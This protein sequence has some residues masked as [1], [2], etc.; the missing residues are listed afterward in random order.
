MSFVG[1]CCSCQD[2]SGDLHHQRGE[3]ESEFDD[4]ILKVFRPLVQLSEADSIFDVKRKIAEQ[5]K[6]YAD[7][8]RQELRLEPKGKF[9]K[10][11]ERLEK[12][13][14][15]NGAI[16]Y[17]K[18]RGLQ[19]GWTTVF[20][21]EYAGPLLVYMWLYTRPWLFYGDAGVNKPIQ[22]VVK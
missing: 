18:D 10:D 20:L 5:K 14:V 8:N 22:P 13:G 11:E 15:S 9:V 7:I 21:A 17:F 1:D 12:L 6:K 2:Q 19:I 4:V 16:L 3:S